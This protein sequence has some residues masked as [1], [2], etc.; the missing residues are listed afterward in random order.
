MWG[1]RTK[2]A[3]TSLFIPYNISKGPPVQ[4][5]GRARPPTSF[6]APPGAPSA[7]GAP[8]YPSM[9]FSNAPPTSFGMPQPYGHTS[10]PYPTQAMHPT[11][12]SAPMH[13]AYPPQQMPYPSQP[14]PTPCYPPNAYPPN[15][16][17]PATQSAY[18]QHQSYNMYPNLQQ[19]SE[20][21]ECFNNTASSPY[22]CGPNAHMASPHQG[23]NY[24][25]G[26]GVHSKYLYGANPPTAA[27]R[28]A[29]PAPR[30][31]PKVRLIAVYKA[32]TATNEIL[33]VFGVHVLKRRRLQ[34][35][36][37]TSRIRRRSCVGFSSRVCGFCCR[38]PPQ[39]C[40]T[41]TS[42]P[43]RTRKRWEKPWRDL[44][45]MRRLLSRFSLTAAICS[46]RRSRRSLRLFMGR[47][48]EPLLWTCCWK[49]RVT[50]YCYYVSVK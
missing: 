40:L 26:Q 5:P 34:S 23:G 3:Y 25:G 10:A 18:P 8:S 48:T 43:E 16:N 6:G 1:L 24:P 22:P 29:T 14:M 50:L 27:P 4:F 2:S 42:T 7:P 37:R 12:S 33:S 46:A 47:Y 39:L 30:F 44:A 49:L 31:A 36:R 13:N 11:P 45:P 21:R 19:T 17:P 9:G 20:A 38:S 32:S 35:Y 41:V 15:P 28:G